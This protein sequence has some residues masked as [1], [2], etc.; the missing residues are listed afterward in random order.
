M[1]NLPPINSSV[2]VIKTLVEKDPRLEQTGR[3]IQYSAH[4]MVCVHFPDMPRG[5]G[6]FFNAHH[7]Q[8]IES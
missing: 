8:N 4:G 7:L 3:V 6:V 5:Q 1:A 2:K